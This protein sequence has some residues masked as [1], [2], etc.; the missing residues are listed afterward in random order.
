MTE[1]PGH[2]TPGQK[3]KNIMGRTFFA[4]W[5]DLWSLEFFN[6]LLSFVLS[7]TMSFALVHGMIALNVGLKTDL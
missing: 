4:R 7:W 3:T 1:G 6:G 2:A 5:W